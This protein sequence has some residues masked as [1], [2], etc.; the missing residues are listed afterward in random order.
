VLK[1][2]T[3]PYLWFLMVFTIRLGQCLRSCNI[4]SWSHDSHL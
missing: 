3:D 1:N 2:S 4:S